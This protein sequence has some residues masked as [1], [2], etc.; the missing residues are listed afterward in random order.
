MKSEPNALALEYQGI[1]GNASR[2]LDI[3]DLINNPAANR[4]CSILSLS[5]QEQVL[6]GLFLE[7]GALPNDIPDPLLIAH[8]TAQPLSK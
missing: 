6:D 8:Y 2:K 4:K 1:Y 7:L 3:S 5:F